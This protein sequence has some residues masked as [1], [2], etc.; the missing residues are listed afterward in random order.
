MRDNI[1]ECSSFAFSICIK[2]C[3][4]QVY[5]SIAIYLYFPGHDTIPSKPY[6]KKLNQFLVEMEF[7]ALWAKI[8]NWNT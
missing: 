5:F 4:W 3:C 7:S 2:V 1:F 6:W 8:R